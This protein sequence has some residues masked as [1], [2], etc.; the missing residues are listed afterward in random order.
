M[1]D[2]SHTGIHYRWKDIDQ[3]DIFTPK[4]RLYFLPNFGTYLARFETKL[5]AKQQPQRFKL[6]KINR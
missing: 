4:L 1:S 6:E 2:A 3:L 5:D